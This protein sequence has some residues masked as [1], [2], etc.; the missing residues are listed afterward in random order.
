MCSSF[1]FLP[2]AVASGLSAS[3]PCAL[4]LIFLLLGVC[5]SGLL[6]KLLLLKILLGL[7]LFL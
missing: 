4:R 2:D 7:I 1:I 5:A 6:L 3:L